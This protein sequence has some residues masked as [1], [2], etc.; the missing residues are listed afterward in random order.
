MQTKSQGWPHQGPV[1]WKCAIRGPQRP[2]PSRL[3]IVP[4]CTAGSWSLTR[5]IKRGGHPKSQWTYG[6]EYWA[7]LVFMQRLDKYRAIEGVRADDRE[8]RWLVPLHGRCPDH[9]WTGIGVGGAFY[10]SELV[11]E[12]AAKR[13]LAHCCCAG[14][15]PGSLCDRFDAECYEIMDPIHYLRSLDYSA[16]REAAMGHLPPVRTSFAA[17]VMYVDPMAPNSV[18][19]PIGLCDSNEPGTGVS[20]YVPFVKPMYDGQ[21]SY[22]EESEYR[23]VWELEDE[24]PPQCTVPLLWNLPGLL[25]RR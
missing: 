3:T 15:P 8:G 6:D 22:D 9:L 7:G 2:P 11:F 18:A 1:F 20:P 23:I 19:S 16:R 21:K 25:E 12:S 4:P 17:P 24:A 14:L 10:Y 5:Y 13:I